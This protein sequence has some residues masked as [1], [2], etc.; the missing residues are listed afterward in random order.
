MS[1]RVNIELEHN[2]KRLDYYTRLKEKSGNLSS[3]EKW[4]EIYSD[5]VRKLERQVQKLGHGLKTDLLSVEAQ[6]RKLRQHG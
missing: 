3:V 6:G 5:R 2:R 1:S 4:I